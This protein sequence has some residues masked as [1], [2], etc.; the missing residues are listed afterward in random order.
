MVK[1]QNNAWIVY[2]IALIAIVALILAIVAIN[3]ANMTGN[4]FWDFLKKQETMETQV[5]SGNY[6]LL[7]DAFFSSGGVRSQLEGYQV[8]YNENGELIYEV[9]NGGRRLKI[10]EDYKFTLNSED[11]SS[12]EISPQE[13]DALYG[14]FT[15]VRCGCMLGNA[16]GTSCSSHCSYTLLQGQIYDCEGW[17]SGDLCSTDECVVGIWWSIL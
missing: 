12:G 4:P 15:G 11:P 3:K 14:F 1:K 8:K 10:G 2:V 5:V 6:G 17:C 9:L 7:G 13:E 16:G